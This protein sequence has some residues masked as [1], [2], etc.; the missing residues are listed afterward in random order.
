M[1]SYLENNMDIKDEI[2]ITKYKTLWDL[3]KLY[4]TRRNSWNTLFLSI[5]TI[6]TGA[7]AFGAKSSS[8]LNGDKHNNGGLE[9]GDII[10]PISSIIGIII[11]ALWFLMNK[12]LDADDKVVYTQV[13]KIEETFEDMEINSSK[14]QSG[15]D[16]VSISKDARAVFRPS[17]A[18]PIK[19]YLKN[20]SPQCLQNIPVR[21][22][23][24]S[25]PVI[26]SIIYLGICVASMPYNLIDKLPKFFSSFLIIIGFIA[27]ITAIFALLVKISICS[28]CN[29]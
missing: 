2:I 14:L 7:L 8:I 12:R 27:T 26:F 11:C 3:R 5:N 18:Q 23:L 9:L 19:P 29:D 10:F 21:C 13:N 15:D 28:R 4:H 1:P 6:A 24:L 17:P 25:L 16:I 20:A 22:I